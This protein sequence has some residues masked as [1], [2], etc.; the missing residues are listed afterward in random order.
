MKQS[1]P[2][3]SLLHTVLALSNLFYQT[4]LKLCLL[5]WISWNFLVL[6]NCP[7]LLFSLRIFRYAR[8]LGSQSRADREN[9]QQEMSEDD[10]LFSSVVNFEDYF[11]SGFR[12]TLIR[13]RPLNVDTPYHHLHFNLYLVLSFDKT[14]DV[15]WFLCSLSVG[16]N[17]PII[18]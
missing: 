4:F 8:T 16:K 11:A 17:S 14:L 2:N 9:I 15:S 3:L 7:V 13:F 18:I 12:R 10:N 5:V 1:W 6:F